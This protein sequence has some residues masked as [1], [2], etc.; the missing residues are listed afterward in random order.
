M[1]DQVSAERG[2]EPVRS[3]L[4]ASDAAAQLAAAQAARASVI[5]HLDHRRVGIEWI[6]GSAAIALFLTTLAVAEFLGEYRLGLVAIPMYVL[7]WL[8]S[9]LGRPG[10]RPRAQRR[11]VVVLLAF[12]VLWSLPVICLGARDWRALALSLMVS[13]ALIVVGAVA[14]LRRMRRSAAPASPDR[15]RLAFP[16]RAWT[17]VTGTALGALTAI[18]FAREPWADSI[19]SASFLIAGG[20]AVIVTLTAR[21]RFAPTAAWRVWGPIHIAAFGIG[22]VVL[23]ATEVMPKMALG[24]AIW[25]GIAAAL[26]L[27]IAAVVPGRTGRG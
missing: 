19:R 13:L 9:E 21:L 6:L 10:A 27:V 24:P 16:E 17:A 26:P 11:V 20:I 5:G 3:A 23:C 18:N 1:S 22:L 12:V 4:T 2:A 15:M 7:P 14:G 25:L 8:S